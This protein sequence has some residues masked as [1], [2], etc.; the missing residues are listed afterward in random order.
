MSVGKYSPTVSNSYGL[1]QGWWEKNG[2][3]Y[4]NGI[5][6]ESDLDDEGFDSYGYSEK[7]GDGP[8]RA[9][10][11]ESEYLEGDRDEDGEFIGHLA[12]ESV[13]RNWSRV[14]LGV[15]HKDTYPRG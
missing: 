8:D 2:G 4:G 7:Y 10:Y 12:Y 1:D 3:G 15:E 13:A 9:G 14:I 6:P 11:T 5:D